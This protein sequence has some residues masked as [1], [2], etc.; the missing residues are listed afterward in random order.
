MHSK[1]DVHELIKT[2]RRLRA[3]DDGDHS[4]FGDALARNVLGGVSKTTVQILTDPLHQD[5]IKTGRFSF[6]YVKSAQLAN[7]GH[8]TSFL[9]ASVTACSQRAHVFLSKKEVLHLHG[10]VW[11]AVG[12]KKMFQSGVLHRK[13]AVDNV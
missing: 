7:H 6:C 2:L 13:D 5:W 1:E 10:M 4:G 3:F 8:A 12:I 9:Y 11:K